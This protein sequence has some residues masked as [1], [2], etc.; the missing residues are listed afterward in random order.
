[1]KHATIKDVRVLAIAAGTSA[2]LAATS[3]SAWAACP[4]SGQGGV[5]IYLGGNVTVVEEVA[6]AGF[7]SRLGLYS[8]PLP[9]SLVDLSSVTPAATAFIMYNWNRN[10]S[11]LGQA[12]P[13]TV[14]FDPSSFGIPPGPVD[15]GIFVQNTVQTYFM[16]SGAVNPDGIAHAK[17][18]DLGGG[19]FR[20]GFEDLFGGGD[21]DFND[22]QFR[23]S[24]GISGE[25]LIKVLT[26]G[27]NADGDGDIDLVVTVG[28][29]ATV[30]YDFTIFYN[31]D[32]RVLV[33]DTIPAE[34]IIDPDFLPNPDA[35]SGT[36]VDFPAGKGPKSKSATKIEWDTDELSS[37]RVDVESR[38]SPG[39]NGKFAPTSCGLLTL[40]DGAVA[41]QVDQVTGELILDAGG[42]PIVV[43]GPTDGI[44][45]I[46]VG[47]EDIGQLPLGYPR[48]G[49]GDFDGDGLT[50][51]Q[52]AFNVGSDPC[53]VDTDGDGANDPV[54]SNPTDPN[55]Q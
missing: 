16:G 50:D 11:I 43:H 53:L 51:A 19:T 20:V 55:V 46:A 32:E 34:W 3:G 37:L 25:E 2:L 10:Q 35:S 24:G 4:D 9:A 48:D 23:F 31:D 1:M 6:S 33:V 26:S 28:S 49:S 52:E 29:P 42:N 54:D 12:F 47:D 17:V 39:R 30:E 38:P 21:C 14:T 45:L 8:A 13:Y 7:T 41:L 5:L 40:N 22:N 15:L 36:V 44:Q 18:T 27:P